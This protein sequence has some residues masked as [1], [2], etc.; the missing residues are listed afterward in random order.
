MKNF[1]ND[2]VNTEE[3]I[4][5]VG[6]FLLTAHH[7][8]VCSEKRYRFFSSVGIEHNN[9][10]REGYVFREI[11]NWLYKYLDKKLEP[12]QL[13]AVIFGAWFGLNESSIKILSSEK[14]KDLEDETLNALLCGAKNTEVEKVLNSKMSY[15]EKTK[16]L[17]AAP[18][19]YVVEIDGKF[20]RAKRI[21]KFLE[22]EESEIRL[23]IQ[24]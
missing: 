23:E 15:I 24:P 6:W 2:Y 3:Y 7:E 18:E 14:C 9:L 11:P 16:K 21:G 19:F 12:N 5:S 13:Y 4:S 8:G 17:Y 22:L 20:Q 1:I 10:S